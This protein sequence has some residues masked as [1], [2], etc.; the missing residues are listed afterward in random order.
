MAP[1]SALV[2]DN[3]AALAGKPG[4]HAFIVGMSDYPHLLEPDPNNP[5][6]SAPHFGL[7]KLASPALSACRIARALSLW[8]PTL[9]VR[10]ATV[11]LLLAA[12]PEEHLADHSLAKGAGRPSWD[13]FAA[14]AARWR[15]DVASHPDN[16]AVFY[17]G[18]H[19]AQQRVPNLVLLLEGFGDGVGGY[20]NHGVDAHRL[21]RGMVASKAHPTMGRRQLFMFDACRFT[22]PAMVAQE[23]EKVRDIWPPVDTD[24]DDRNCTVLYATAPGRLSYGIRGRTSLFARA[25]IRAINRQGA[26][27]DRGII[28]TNA[29]TWSVCATSLAA[30]INELVKLDTNEQSVEQAGARPDF[31]L[32]ELFRPPRIKI[33]LQLQP[34]DDHKRAELALRDDRFK[35]ICQS[36]API[37]PYPYEPL[38]HAGVYIAELK[39]KA[40]EGKP[41]ALLTRGFKVG[42]A[43]RH[44]LLDTAD[45]SPP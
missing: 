4:L 19:G 14:A 6:N 18:G 29:R 32:R 3:R 12:S 2:V 35:P 17:F 5:D 43:D 8:S 31:V 22:P 24:K 13:N 28:G 16:I 15:E 38:L 27:E 20:L 41:G 34:A 44:V 37:D 7:R 30:S 11:R 25:F 26:Q 40:A 39:L 23:V 9:T 1:D 33:S 45:T 21:M 42:P 10:L 36:G